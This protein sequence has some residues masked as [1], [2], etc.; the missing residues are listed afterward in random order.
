MFHCMGI[1]GQFN[2]FNFKNKVIVISSSKK[3]ILGPMV[4]RGTEDFPP[5]RVPRTRVSVLTGKK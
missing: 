3:A 4:L 1:M 2:V 5:T